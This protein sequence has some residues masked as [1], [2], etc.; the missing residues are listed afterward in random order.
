MIY[1]VN[2]LA[3]SS[4]ILLFFQKKHIANR[5]KVIMILGPKDKID[6]NSINMFGKIEYLKFKDI[7]GY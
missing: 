5:N 2:Y 6:L 1:I 7:F 3:F 4:K